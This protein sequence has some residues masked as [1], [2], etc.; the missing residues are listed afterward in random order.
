MSAREPRF[1]VVH[2]D[3]GWFARFVA[4]NGAKVWQTEVYARR[5]FAVRAISLIAGYDVAQHGDQS[6]VLHPSGL[7]GLLEVRDQDERTPPPV[8]A[9]D[10]HV[11]GGWV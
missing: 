8:P 1:E 11:F 7:F 4:S 3:A 9:S 5:K 2:S 6:E 10:F